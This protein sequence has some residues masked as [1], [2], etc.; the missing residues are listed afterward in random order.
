MALFSVNRYLGTDES[1]GTCQSDRTNSILQ[2]LKADAERRKRKKEVLSPNNNDQSFSENNNVEKAIKNLN[3]SKTP[4]NLH[5]FPL[6]DTPK[7]LK[8]TRTEHSECDL[9]PSPEKVKRKHKNDK[10]KNKKY[11]T[12]CTAR[13]DEDSSL[14][15]VSMETEGQTTELSDAE[16][17]LE[18]QDSGNDT[19][20]TD[21]SGVAPEERD[22]SK[23]GPHEIGGYTVLGD[24]KPKH[25]EKVKRV[26]PEWL[27]KPS[28]VS[29]DINKDQTPVSQVS[30]IHQH[31]LDKLQENGITHFF[32]VQAQIIPFMLSCVRSGYHIGPGGYQPPDVCCSAP[33]GSGKTLAF[34]LPIVQAL[35]GRTVCQIRALIV[36]P[37]QD[38]ARQVFRVFH[39][40][41]QGTN[42]KVGLIIGQKTF[43]NEQQSLVKYRHSGYHSQ[44][45]I[46][47]ATPGRLVDHINKTEGFDLR[48]LRFLVIDEADRMMAEIKQEWLTQVEEAVYTTRYGHGLYPGYIRP[49]PGHITVESA[50]KIQMPLQK[51]LF[52]ATL[53][54]NPEKLQQLKLYQP[55]LFT[56]VGGESRCLGPAKINTKADPRDLTPAKAKSKTE[57]RGLTPAKVNSKAESQELTSEKVNTKE[58]L[59]MTPAP[60]EVSGMEDRTRAEFAGKYTTPIGLMEY[61]VESPMQEKPL[62][63]LHLI[64]NLGYRQVLCFTNSVEAT[65]RLYLLMK[66]TGGIQVKEFSSK[67]HVSKRK[68]I[69]EQF[70]AGK[71]DL[72]ICSD[73]MA[74]GMDVEN[75]KY[76]ISYDSPLFIK[77]Y[78]HRVGRTARA[79]KLGTAF[80]LLQKKE[81]FHFKKMLREAGKSSIKEMKI[82]KSD[83]E[84]LV[85]EFKEALQKVPETLKSERRRTK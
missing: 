83:L 64:H 3:K 25:V 28:M 41:C 46:I 1:E 67:L 54:Q 80:T 8:R 84:P 48:H 61:F 65:H 70:K 31:I 56:S 29:A 68:R 17:R 6:E 37:V 39:T 78:I 35:V 21:L 81:V 23:T 14:L 63:V 51:L 19:E 72:L 76:V 55:R 2:K 30:G 32:P 47:V 36:L 12:D 44:V 15:S 79:G 9:N 11:D 71:I 26:L 85:P 42:V 60:K 5:C 50:A 69:L 20:G 75:V 4:K 33:T 58:V 18:S 22:S 49:R 59:G 38:L 77:T 10:R 24:V 40:Y 45:D 43:Q 74:R 82:S 34:A 52:S 53:S 27:A 66:M 16:D 73:A 62:M 7:K 13:K 57:S